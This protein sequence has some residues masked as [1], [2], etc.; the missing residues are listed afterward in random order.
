VRKKRNKHNKFRFSIYVYAYYSGL[1]YSSV[2]P[3][4]EWP[5]LFLLLRS[6]PFYVALGSLNVLVTQDAAG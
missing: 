3:S 1:Q 6:G 2:H 4:I 5:N